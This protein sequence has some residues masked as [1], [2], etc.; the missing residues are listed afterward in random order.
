MRRQYEM[1]Y[2]TKEIVEMNIV[3]SRECW[4][5]ACGDEHQLCGVSEP[6]APGQRLLA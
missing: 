5:E 4:L 2:D 6:D 1:P 3:A